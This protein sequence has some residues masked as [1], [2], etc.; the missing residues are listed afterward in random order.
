MQHPAR[1]GFRRTTPLDGQR[2]WTLVE[3]SISLAI[4]SLLFLMIGSLMNS[5]S[6]AVAEMSSDVAGEHALRRSLSLLYDDV[7]VA[8]LG[9][10]VVSPGSDNDTLSLQTPDPSG[11]GTWGDRSVIQGDAVHYVHG[12]RVWSAPW[13]DPASSVGP[14]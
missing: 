10:L 12:Q 1:I 3:L 4:S 2:G 7:K 13:D 11:T 9:T 6:I 14:E 5:S 8:S